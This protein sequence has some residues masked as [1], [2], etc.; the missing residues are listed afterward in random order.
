MRESLLANLYT[1]AS[2]QPNLFTRAALQPIRTRMHNCNSI[3]YA[4]QL[5]RLAR[6][7]IMQ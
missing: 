3:E 1:R 2:L 7:T 4:S 6:R 5:D